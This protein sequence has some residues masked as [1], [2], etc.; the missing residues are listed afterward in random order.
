MPPRGVRGRPLQGAF[1]QG[2]TAGPQCRDPWRQAMTEPT[3]LHC[4]E[5]HSV[6]HARP[7]LRQDARCTACRAQLGRGRRQRQPRPSRKA[8]A[9]P[10]A[11]DGGWI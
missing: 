7:R 1:S 3:T 5:C 2:G 9:T 10:N 6:L 4:K 8:G 11:H